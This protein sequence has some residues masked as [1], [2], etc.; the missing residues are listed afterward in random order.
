MITEAYGSVGEMTDNVACEVEDILSALHLVCGMS[1][2]EWSVG[3]SRKSTFLELEVA[4]FFSV[5]KYYEKLSGKNSG[6]L[7]VI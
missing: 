1:L 7:E 2:E 4:T 3:C 5:Y 6:H